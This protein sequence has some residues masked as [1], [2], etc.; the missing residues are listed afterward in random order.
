VFYLFSFNLF[1]QPE[2]D[3]KDIEEITNKD[4]DL[5]NLPVVDNIDREYF[6]RYSSPLKSIDIEV[7]KSSPIERLVVRKNTSFVKI[8]NNSIY[9]GKD[10]F[11]V[12][13]HT[14]PD[15]QGFIYVVDKNGNVKYKVHIDSTEP[16]KEELILHEPPKYFSVVNDK[17]IKK[18]EFDQDLEFSPEPF[19]HYDLVWAEFTRDLLD[20]PNAY[21]AKGYRYGANFLVNWK[22]NFRYG[23]AAEYQEVDHQLKDGNAKFSAITLGPVFHSSSFSIFDNPCEISASAL[24]GIKADLVTEESD[25]A[26]RSYRLAPMNISIAIDRPFKNSYGDFRFGIEYRKQWVDVLSS[27]EDVRLNTTS[28]TNNFLGFYVAQSF[29]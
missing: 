21:S 24:W 29:N 25:G 8:E 17:K 1:A 27:S 16:L 6:R 9:Y 13:G 4:V 14:Q 20:D 19:F 11:I 5:Q 7:I 26:S 18:K 15:E 28:T 22:T 3:T 23:L 2:L 12:K 10:S